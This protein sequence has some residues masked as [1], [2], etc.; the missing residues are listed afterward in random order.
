MVVRRAVGPGGI[1]PD[2]G[3][4]LASPS[5]RSTSRVR[6]LHAQVDSFAPV[7]GDARES[8]TPFT[9]RS[10]TAHSSRADQRFRAE[11][12]ADQPLARRS[13]SG[14]GAQAPAMGRHAAEMSA[15]FL[16]EISGHVRPCKLAAGFPRFPAGVDST[17]GATRNLLSEPAAELLFRACRGLPRLASKLLH[18]AL[19]VAHTRDQAFLDD[20][21]VATAIAYLSHELPSNPDTLKPRTQTGTRS[22]R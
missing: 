16:T 13:T 7:G 14:R 6:R 11:P 22:R 12:R 10:R 19:I 5:G 4:R 9:D 18:A 17:A 8:R 20:S 2:A 1:S 15:R 3:E 21:V